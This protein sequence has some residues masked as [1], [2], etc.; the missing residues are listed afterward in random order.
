MLS[1]G[2]LAVKEVIVRMDWFIWWRR[3]ELKHILS[4]KKISF[5]YQGDSMNVHTNKSGMVKKGW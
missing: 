4:S 5:I 2:S 1:I 3:G